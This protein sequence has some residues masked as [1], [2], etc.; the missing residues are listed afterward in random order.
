LLGSVADKV[1]RGA[2]QAVLVVPTRR[3]EE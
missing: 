1:I 2:E 3:E